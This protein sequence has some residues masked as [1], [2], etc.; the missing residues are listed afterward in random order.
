MS[1]FQAIYGRPPHVIPRFEGGSMNVEALEALLL[2][3]D[4]L[5]SDLKDSLLAA[6]HRMEQQA[7]KKRR[8][9]EFEAGDLVWLQLQPYRQSTVAQRCS[10]KRAKCFFGPYKIL[11]RIGV[12]EYRVELPNGSR[13][14]PI[15]HVSQLK[16]YVGSS[17]TPVAPFPVDSTGLPT[18]TPL[19]VVSSRVVLKQGIRKT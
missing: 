8:D 3:R 17:A 9:L 16:P 12:V 1:P 4:Q 14:H 2:E 6:Q 7:N 10:E 13:I 18:L 15:F 11:E 5:L 19:V